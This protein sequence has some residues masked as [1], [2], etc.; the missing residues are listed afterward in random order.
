MDKEEILKY[1][2]DT[3]EL[4]TTLINRVENEWGEVR[5][6][7]KYAIGERVYAEYPDAEVTIEDRYWNSEE[8]MWCYVFHSRSN[9]MAWDKYSTY[10]EDGLKPLGK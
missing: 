10:P 7:P 3:R 2:N 6:E 9:L 4:I 5:P 8:K 1:L